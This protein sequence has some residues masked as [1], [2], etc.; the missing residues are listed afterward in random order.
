MLR[1]SAIALTLLLP[2]SVQAQSKQEDCGYQG[3][4]A[5]AIQDARLARVKEGDV[6]SHIA[7]QSPSWPDKYNTAIPLMTPWVYEQRMRDLRRE[8]LGVLWTTMCMAG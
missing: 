1:P 2:L 5:K 7:A 8:D 3:Q 4:V 6:A